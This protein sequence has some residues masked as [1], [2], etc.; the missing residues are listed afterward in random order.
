MSNLHEELTNK[1]KELLEQIKAI[2]VLLYNNESLQIEHTPKKNL[3]KTLLEVIANSGP[4]TATDLCSKIKLCGFSPTNGTINSYLYSLRQN[5]LLNYRGRRG[6]R[7][8]YLTKNGENDL[9]DRR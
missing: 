1:R 3:T 6:Q 2:D 9:A 7:S 4:I 8:Y 5:G